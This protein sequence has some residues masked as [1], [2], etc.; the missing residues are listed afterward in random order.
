MSNIQ[1]FD[2]NGIAVMDSREV[3]EWVEKNHKDLMRDIRGYEEILTGASLRSLDFFIPS[4]Y[5]DAK[6]EERPNYLI[7]RKGCEMV[8][9]KMTGQ[10]GVLFTATCKS[11]IRTMPLLQYDKHNPEDLDT[12]GEDHIADETRYMCMARPMEPVRRLPREARQY[13]PL[14]DDDTDLFRAL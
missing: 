4:T 11:F 1:I 9:N 3:A 14:E 5:K 8:A 2:H 6:G 12:D 7:T 13:N 10:K